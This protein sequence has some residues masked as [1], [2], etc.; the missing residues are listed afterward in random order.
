M[1]GQI[2]SFDDASGAGLISGDDGIRY[3]FGREAVS[4]PAAITAGLRVDF[5]PV[6]GEAT[7]LMLLAAAPARRHCQ[8]SYRRPGR[9]LTFPLLPQAQAPPGVRQSRSDPLAFNVCRKRFLLRF[10]WPAGCSSLCCHGSSLVLW[11]CERV[12]WVRVSY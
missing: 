8:C 12:G 2:L 3:T 7:N 1:R 10:C 11:W 4:P 9:S 6:A 5:V